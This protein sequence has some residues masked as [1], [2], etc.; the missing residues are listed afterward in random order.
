MDI[1]V[2]A[3]DLVS[4]LGPALPFLIGAAQ[5][6]TGQVV[7]EAIS[8]TAKKLWSKLHSKLE[9]KPSIKE[10]AL[11]LASHPDDED[12][13]AALRLQLKKLL[14][15]DT[16]LANEL[17]SIVADARRPG[18][19]VTASGDRA[20]AVG[21]NLMG[22]TMITGDN[23]TVQRGKYNIKIDEAKGLAIGDDAQ[24]VLPN[25]EDGE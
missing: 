19:I 16:E 8:A 4:I 24:V 3:R 18:I 6:A 11:D 23:N 17:A 13:Q 5:E 21:G 1:A 9:S 20:I 7:G 2:L 14:T 25:D 15:D 12:A 22:S 10:V